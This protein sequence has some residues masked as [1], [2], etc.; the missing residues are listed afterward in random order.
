MVSYKWLLV[1]LSSL[2]ALRLININ[3]S[4]AAA[5]ID[6]GNNRKLKIFYTKDDIRGWNSV[7]IGKVIMIGTSLKSKEK[8]P[9][10]KIH[11]N[12]RATVRLYS[13]EGIKINDILYIINEKNLIIARITVLSIFYS[14][15]FGFL[16]VGDGNLIL[17]N[18]GDRV[19]HRREADYS[20][21]A[22]A[23]NA[24]GDYYS[25]I[26]QT[27]KAISHY[28]KT[29]K[30]DSGNPEAHLSLGYIYLNNNMLNFAY[31]EFHEAYRWIGRLY[32]NEDKYLLLKGL[33]ETRY[34]EVYYQSLPK[35]IRLNYINDGIKYS[36]EAL[37]IYP[38]SKEVNLYLGMFYYKNPEPNDI[39]AKNQ[40]LKVI[41]LD[42]NNIDAYIALAE[43]Y[44]KHRNNK[45]A[46]QY[47]EQALRIDPLNKRAKFIISISE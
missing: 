43:L 30:H 39:D 23:H 36:K 44:Y 35:E 2:L 24:R 37:R 11:E 26:G 6:K 5:L 34:K 15:T 14:K 28:N 33:V 41:D 10:S 31:K 4:Y 8:M 21:Y 22:F 19:V 7:L 27:G 9:Q 29:L 16:L 17:A 45:K 18:I 20:K 46:R 47:A 38:N 13:S 25:D 40:F 42:P 12:T 32:D 3:T 1:T